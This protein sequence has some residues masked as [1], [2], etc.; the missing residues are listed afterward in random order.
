MN[1]KAQIQFVHRLAVL[2]ESGVSLGEAMEILQDLESKKNIY[3][4]QKIKEEVSRGMSFHRS[5]CATGI[6]FDPVL[7]S[8]ISIGE[9]S[10]I[11]ASSLRQAISLK[12][13][14]SVIKRK[15]I[16]ALIYPMFIGLATIAMTLF[17]ILY[18]FPK[19]IPLFSS[20]NIT[21]PLLTR[22]VRGLYALLATHGVV[23]LVVL[24]FFIFIF[25]FL[26]KRKR[27]FRRK[28]EHFALMMPGLGILL[29]KYHI[30]SF[31]RSIGTLLECGQTLPLILRQLSDGSV[32]EVYKE[33]WSRVEKQTERGVQLSV[34]LGVFKRYVPRTVTDMLSI[35]ERT[36]S[37]STMC[38]HVS[39]MYEEELDT[40]CKQL[41]TMIEPV[42][43][44]G[45]GLIVG[46]VA[47]SIILPIYEVTS[48][49]T[50]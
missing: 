43:M 47:L 37:L 36:G 25:I 20:M 42:L 8:M 38:L 30:T 3:I 44:V 21:L 27:C 28:V 5:I 33:V 12:E 35:G 50:R 10:G 11:L 6:K 7:L 32:S 2:L 16:G 26:F 23:I 15:L 29:Q 14:S 46:S 39:R 24:I 49:L 31:V 48:N 13:K 17:L 41:S 4:I 34:S 19:I 9:N 40:F 22:I 1:K 18:I 45:M